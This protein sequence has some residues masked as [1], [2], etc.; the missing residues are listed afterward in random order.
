MDLYPSS[1]ENLI[2][3]G[4]FNVCVEGIYMSGFCDTL[5]LKS[6][7]KDATCYKNPIN[8]SSILTNNPRSFQNFLLLRQVYPISI[9]WK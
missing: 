5:G 6:L 7:I 9:E 8:P 2:I 3:A 1:Y 4:E